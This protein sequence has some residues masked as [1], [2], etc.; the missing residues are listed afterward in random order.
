MCVQY[1][2][3]LYFLV[4][5]PLLQVQLSHEFTYVQYCHAELLDIFVYHTL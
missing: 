5:F 2:T 4:I 3:R 1:I